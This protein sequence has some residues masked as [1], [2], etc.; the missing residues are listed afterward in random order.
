MHA[1]AT[2]LP[3]TVQN[4]CPYTDPAPPDLGIDVKTRPSINS[5]FPKR[6]VTV[7]IPTLVFTRL[8]LLDYVA[9]SIQC[10]MPGVEVSLGRIHVSFPD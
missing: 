8:A 4:T 1:A 10:S 2:V 5:H 6:V 3:R 9:S 7:G